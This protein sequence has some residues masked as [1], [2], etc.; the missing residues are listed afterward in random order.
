[1]NRVEHCDEQPSIVSKLVEG[2]L[3]TTNASNL[4]LP[5]NLSAILSE[6]FRSGSSAQEIQSISKERPANMLAEYGIKVRDFAYES[7]LPPIAP[8]PH[9]PLQI[10]P[11]LSPLK[12]RRDYEEEGDE[13][14]P[15]VGQTLYF[16]SEIGG[17]SQGARH[18]KKTKPLERTATEPADG[19]STMGLHPWRATGFADLS[20]AAKQ[21]PPTSQPST[22][23]R[24]SVRN[25]DTPR[26]HPHNMDFSSPSQPGLQGTSQESEGWIDTPLVTPN[27]SLQYAVVDNSAIL[28]PQPDTN[29]EL[30]VPENLTYSQLRFSPERSQSDAPKPRS[31]L[32]SLFPSVKP[33]STTR[34]SSPDCSP[35]RSPSRHPTSMGRSHG[36]PPK[37]AKHD[38]DSAAAPLS[39]S[40]ALPR[41]HLRERTTAS[42]R[43]PSRTNGRARGSH[44]ISPR[45]GA[46]AKQPSPGKSQRGAKVASSSR[47]RPG[48]QE[49]VALK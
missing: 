19:P 42:P 47:R 45:Q 3:S 36:S 32:P 38:H 34:Q 30:P 11:G 6:T 49:P 12:R 8:V 48:R 37:R 26:S 31:L 4:Q 25:V 27:G 44:S 21:T 22:P 35:T 7:T 41:Y 23:S 24:S 1:M 33:S 29:S 46:T 40:T 16:D 5:V 13:D 28:A 15:Y 43:T 39:D 2:E 9:V 14:E 20:E 10:Q 17:S 18:V